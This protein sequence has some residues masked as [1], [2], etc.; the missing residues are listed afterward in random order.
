MKSISGQIFIA[1]LLYLCQVFWGECSLVVDKFTTSFSNFVLHSNNNSLHYSH[2]IS[3]PLSDLYL[4]AGAQTCTSSP[5]CRSCGRSPSSH[6]WAA[7]L[8]TSSSTCADVSR[9]P[10]TPSLPRKYGEETAA[11]KQCPHQSP[12][13]IH[14]QCFFFFFSESFSLEM[15]EMDIRIRHRLIW[16]LSL[17]M[18]LMQRLTDDSLLGEQLL[19]QLLLHQIRTNRQF[20]TSCNKLK[21]KINRPTFSPMKDKKWFLFFP[22]YLYFFSYFFLFCFLTGFY[23]FFFLLF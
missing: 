22:I 1:V 15:C 11:T 21:Q 4:L 10:A 23:L 5:R 17:Y 12:T 9:H 16:K 6:W 19:T 13:R 20:Y 7:C 3:R 2:F 14:S 8:F 18:C